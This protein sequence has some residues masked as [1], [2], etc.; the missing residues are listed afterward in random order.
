MTLEEA[1]AADRAD[2]MERARERELRAQL[3]LG[4]LGDNTEKAAIEFLL[5]R[6]ADLEHQIDRLIDRMRMLTQLKIRTKL[7]ISIICLDLDIN[8][9]YDALRQSP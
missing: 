2:A 3:E 1:E 6:V 4:N 9:K 8:E 7:K 5:Q